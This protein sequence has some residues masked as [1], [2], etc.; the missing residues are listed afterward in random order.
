MGVVGGER[1]G[2][3]GVMKYLM[4]Q[5]M[6]VVETAR[7]RVAGCVTGESSCGREEVVVEDEGVDE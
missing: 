1:M 2:R 7:G 4:G 5:A 6:V 3:L